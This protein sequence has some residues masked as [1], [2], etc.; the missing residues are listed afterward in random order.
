MT[1]IQDALVSIS[2]EKYTESFTASGF[3]TLEDLTILV[4]ADLDKVLIEVGMLK[5]HTFKLK[6]M[7]ED[8]KL[9]NTPKSKPMI[10]TVIMPSKPKFDLVNTP[11]V[12]IQTKIDV[13]KGSEGPLVRDIGDKTM[14]IKTQLAS[15]LQAKDA[16]VNSLKN[17]ME[18]DLDTYFQALKHLKSMQQTVK[19][20]IQTDIEII[21]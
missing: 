1:S 11:N 15:I 13:L 2:L 20:L 9:G 21:I 7:I 3:L 4:P 12:M 6:K 8:A 14:T 19:E 16:L 5:G 17:F 10:S 18:L